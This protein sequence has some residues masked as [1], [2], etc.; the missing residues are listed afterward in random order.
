[1]LFPGLPHAVREWFSSAARQGARSE[2]RDVSLGPVCVTLIGD[3]RTED[4][5]HELIASAIA[6]FVAAQTSAEY[7]LIYF[8]FR[9]VG[10]V[11]LFLISA[12]A[13]VRK[14]LWRNWWRKLARL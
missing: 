12:K 9:G 13:K 14:T 3:F 10:G 7:V 1:M 8:Y 5:A 2:A 11:I 6:A 4:E